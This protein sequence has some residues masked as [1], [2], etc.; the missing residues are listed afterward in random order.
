MQLILFG[1]LFA[2]PPK[3]HSDEYEAALEAVRQNPTGRNY[4]QLGRLVQEE[5]KRPAWRDLG[6]LQY[7]AE[8]VFASVVNLIPASPNPHPIVAWSRSN[9]HHEGRAW[10]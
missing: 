10:F 1:A 2:S 8:V 5:E 6:A 7:Y 9:T 4:E 3:E